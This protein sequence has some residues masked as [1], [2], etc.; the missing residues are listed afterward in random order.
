[1]PAPVARPSSE[2]DKPPLVPD[3]LSSGLVAANVS[4]RG[5]VV[6][7][8]D[9]YID[10]E[11]DGSVE[12][13]GSTITVGPNARVTASITARR[14]IV[15]GSVQGP[16]TAQNSIELRKTCKLVGNL[17]TPRIAIEDGAYFKGSIDM[18]R[19]KNQACTPSDAV[20]LEERY[21][22][23]VDLKY[24]RGLT[25][26]EEAEFESLASK[27]ASLDASFYEPILER[28]ARSNDV[29]GNVGAP[30]RVG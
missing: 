8:D 24:L 28:L 13:L 20:A 5:S 2:L 22:K 15:L 10:G 11:V 19:P 12:A 17:I 3:P 6:S 26:P 30:L 1:M 16:V 4:V 27:L 9:L 7:S 18:Y 25:K 14:V 21:S 23:L 29:R